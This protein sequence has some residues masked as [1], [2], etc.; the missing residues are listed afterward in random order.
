M[1]YELKRSAY[2]EGLRPAQPGDAP[3][4]QPSR[5]RLRL[6][7]LLDHLQAEAWQRHA[8]EEAA[9]LDWVDLA[10][11][12]I[13]WSPAQRRARWLDNLAA[14]RLHQTSE[15]YD[16]YE[17]LGRRLRCGAH[18][19][20]RDLADLL[21]GVPL[22]HVV[23]R[24]SKGVF[25]RFEDADLEALRAFEL[26][27]LVRFGFRILKGGI[28]SA[29]RHGVWSYHHGDPA[30]YRGGPACFWEMTRGEST[31]GVVLQR[32]TEDLDAGEVLYRSQS[33]LPRT[34][35]VDAARSAHFMKSSIFL[36]RALE[37]LHDTGAACGDH[38]ADPPPPPQ[39]GPLYRKPGNLHAT[40][41]LT[42]L[43]ARSAV[44]SVAN[45]ARRSE[46]SVVLRR[47]DS[48][49]RAGGETR[50]IARLG[51]RGTEAADPFLFVRDGRRYCFFESVP[52]GGELGQI[53]CVQVLDDGSLTEPQTVLSCA[54]HVSYPFVFEWEGDV[55]LAV[56]AGG[57]GGVHVWRAESFPLV[58]RRCRAMLEGERAYDP[59]LLEWR[60]RWYLFVTIDE[61]GGGADDELFLFHADTPLGPWRPHERNP[62]VSDCRAARPAGALFV[63]DGKLVRPAQDCAGGYGKAIALCEVEELSPNAY[64]QRIIG[65]VEGFGRGSIGCHTISQ[66]GGLQAVDVR[67]AV[68][69]RP[70]IARSSSRGAA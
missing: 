5:N 49:L 46:W 15:V 10:V 32:L 40:R 19:G 27:V 47:A 22:L 43:A 61:A 38:P 52:K 37:R 30:A 7:L 54:H 41:L 4:P 60:G 53:R 18:S 24:R 23:P 9:K 11:A 51:G 58:W 29:A 67:R 42:A 14:L 68:L 31:I 66:L 63:E 35:W 13:C 28:L 39:R 65:R 48:P 62:V 45:L 64:R 34:F 50:V 70:R 55:Y 16:L 69:G 12:V 36:R 26:D 3:G 44:N 2:D 21:R 59:T 8:I 25:D 57:V 20:A 33:S 17:R 56:E 6:G 1:G